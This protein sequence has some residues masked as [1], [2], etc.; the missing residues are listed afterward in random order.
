MTR[1]IVLWVVLVSASAGMALH[2]SLRV[3]A[4]EDRLNEIHRAIASEQDRIR[5]LTAEW[6]MLK[7]P[8]R[9]EELASRHIDSLGRI[10]PKQMATLES[11]PTPDTLAVADADDGK[12]AVPPLAVVAPSVPSAS[13][14]PEA[15]KASQSPA[16]PAASVAPA[17]V[18]S[19]RVTPRNTKETD[20]VV[21]PRVAAV[22]AVEQVRAV[23]TA[24]GVVRSA[25]VPAPV[26]VSAPASAPAAPRDELAA[27]IARESAHPSGIG[28]LIEREGRPSGVVLASAAGRTR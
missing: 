6:H 11:I 27:L 7:S 5:V 18:P 25:A 17:T 2:T 3:R 10:S 8:A 13:S 22:R 9:L 24:D 12:V 4:Q 21:A 1:K 23:R 15:G 16:A 28:D 26:S 19:E 20:H 14:A